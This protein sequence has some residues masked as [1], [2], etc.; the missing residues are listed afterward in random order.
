MSLVKFFYFTHSFDSIHICELIFIFSSAAFTAQDL[1]F[2]TVAS[3]FLK[4]NS[5]LFLAAMMF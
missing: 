2:K 5:I 3:I 1:I 4:C